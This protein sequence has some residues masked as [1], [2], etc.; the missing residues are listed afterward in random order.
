MKAADLKDFSSLYISL[1]QFRDAANM[2]TIR[3]S[4]MVTNK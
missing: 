3:A 4:D 1:L 2:E